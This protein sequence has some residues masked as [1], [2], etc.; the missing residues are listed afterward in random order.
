MNTKLFDEDKDEPILEPKP[1]STAENFISSLWPLL[2]A[3]LDRWIEQSLNKKVESI[4][5]AAVD[6]YVSSTE[7][8]SA[9]SESI[10]FDLEDMKCQQDELSKEV[11][12][13][14]WSHF[15]ENIKFNC[16]QDDIEQYSRRNSIRIS[17]ITENKDENTDELVMKTIKEKLNIDITT[18]DL[19]RSHRVGLRKPGKPR[20]IIVKLVRHNKKVEILKNRKNAEDHGIDWQGP[21]VAE[22]GAAVE[23][24]D[25]PC[26]LDD[27]QLASIQAISLDIDN[28][29][30]YAIGLYSRIVSLTYLYIDT[31]FVFTVGVTKEWF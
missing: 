19:D 28:G 13:Q 10:A 9:L 12:D 2:E 20:Q 15:N 7:F 4:A 1:G 18:N 23:V 5:I 3:K 21:S 6:K 31:T 29:D 17:G 22:E 24:P 8:Q 11:S 26:C 25:T 14:K 30:P 16:K 27:A